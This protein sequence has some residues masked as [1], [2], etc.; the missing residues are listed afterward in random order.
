MKKV[1]L[2]LVALLVGL[3]VWGL[4]QSGNVSV[5]VNW[6]ELAGPMKDAV[7]VWEFLIAIVALFSAAILVAFVFAGVGFVVLGCLVLVGLILAAV[8]FPFLLPLL[9][10]LFI[11]WTFVAS[12]RRGKANTI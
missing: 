12:T 7:G 1:V 3:L 11:V 6:H 9:I 5:T 4:I 10:P 8:A 2:I